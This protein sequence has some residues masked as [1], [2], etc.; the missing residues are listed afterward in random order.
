MEE[1]EVLI[2]ELQID[3][4]QGEKEIDQLTKS[5]E[6]LKKQNEELLKVN[7]DLKKAGEE[8]SQEF[9]ENA[10][11]IELNR[12]AIAK[13]TSARRNA[14]NAIKAED[15]SLGALKARLA[16]QKKLRDQVNLSTEEGRKRF[17]ELTKAIKENTE[18]LLKAEKAAGTYT[19]QVG[20]YNLFS[21]EA[22][23]NSGQFGSSLVSITEHFTKLLHPMTAFLA[24]GAGLVKLYV[25][26][27]RG[28]RDLTR[29][30]DTLSSA[31]DVAS[32]AVGDFIAE[33]TGA[34]SGGMG[35][36]EQFVN[37]VLFRV[38]PALGVMSSMA[39]QAK[40]RLRDLEI[41]SQFAAQFAK[42][43]E[44]RIKALEELRDNEDKSL[45][46]RLEAAK[47]IA[48]L[49]EQAGQRTIAVIRAQIQAIKDSTINYA[50]NREAQLQVAE[51]EAKI[52]DE[53][54]K[55]AGKVKGN[56]AT[57][58]QLT[59]EYEELYK[60]LN[61]AAVPEEGEIDMTAALREM[62][63]ES[64]RILTENAEFKRMLDEETTRHALEMYEKEDQ[65]LF[66]RVEK[67]KKV[68]SLLKTMA[69]E[70]A[71]A[72]MMAFS[73]VT[74][75]AVSAFGEQTAAGKFFAL[76]QIA[77][78]A[79]IGVARA[80]AAGADK[81]WP[82]NLVAILSGITA[83]LSGIGQARQVM[84]FARGGDASRDRVK[85]LG[86]G[87]KRHWSGGTKYYGE[88]GNV[89]EVEQGEGIYVLK[90]EAEADTI[91]KLSA[92]NQRHGGVSFANRGWYRAQGGAIETRQAVSQIN[93]NRDVARLANA[94]MNMPPPIVLVEDILAGQNR[95]VSVQERAQV[96]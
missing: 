48:P 20:N 35:P 26:S 27:A 76:A 45:K 77:L 79:G 59:K 81:P 5:I 34:S 17:E 53:L 94:I 75:A 28:A 25:S 37:A 6:E 30:Q 57:V 67:N 88:D 38:S 43:D 42:E 56:V 50:A 64:R 1:K 66:E 78:N 70:L 84:K 96:I 21:K 52:A 8:N 65:A 62:D 69:R 22:I 74:A 73:E 12:D 44:R 47:Q 89:F 14:I 80:T 41:S 85:S 60:R 40:D 82:L 39:A 86:V 18:T 68:N 92:L 4:G 83:V 9:L 71:D 11:Q 61:N 3:R 7:K 33:L 46:E 93:A 31:F 2:L 16:E 32:N 51:L 95:V 19:R 23:A 13:N 10:K 87:G 36:L 63:A 49:L 24:A 90:R 58:R 91:G 29:A 55:T 54:D 72:Q 15:N